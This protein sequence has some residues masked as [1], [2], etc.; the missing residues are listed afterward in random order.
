[1]VLGPFAETKGP[2][3]PGRNPAHSGNTEE[4]DASLHGHDGD[5]ENY[6]SLQMNHLLTV[7][8]DSSLLDFAVRE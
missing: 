1:M 4:L 2:R 6:F 3:P 5:F 7:E 8:L